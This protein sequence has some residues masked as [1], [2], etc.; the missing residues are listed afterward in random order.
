MKKKLNTSKIFIFA[1]ILFLGTLA[2]I[3]G[4]RFIHY[5]R[6]YHNTTEINTTVSEPVSISKHI[7]SF[8]GTEED[9]ANNKPTSLQ[10]DNDG[11]YYF[12]GQVKNNYIYYSGLLWRI[13]KLN[14]D[15][16]VTL[17]TEENQTQ[18]TYG[19][20]NKYEKSYVYNYL[21]KV[22]NNSVFYNNLINTD[23]LTKT[24]YCT[25]IINNIEDIT[26]S[27]TNYDYQITLLS[28]KDYMNSGANDGYLNNGTYFWLMNFN[29]N[30]KLYYVFDKGGVNSTNQYDKIHYGIRPVIS[31]KGDII[32]NGGDGTSEKPF[33]IDEYENYKLANVGIGEYLEYSGYNW[34]IINKTEDAVKVIMDGYIK[35][36]N[37]EIEKTFSTKNN[38]FTP[39]DKNNI[40]YYLNNDFY[41][42]LDNKEYLVKGPFYTGKYSTDSYD[43]RLIY[44]TNTNAYIGLP[45][46]GDLYINSFNNTLTMLGITDHMN[47]IL[48]V[49]DENNSLYT[50][51]INTQEKIRP[52]LYLN[53]SLITL[54]GEGTQKI[55]YIIGR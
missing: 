43:Y 4:Y 3:Y 8:R 7:L 51:K 46:I 5:Y 25:S 50:S 2:I 49:I 55:P 33:Y 44:K 12:K 30:N 41:K 16:T 23:Y 13:V 42:T 24:K 54:N 36:D 1:S 38:T 29:D 17:I 31:I 10:K 34:R 22:D 35:E 19:E 9:I 11:T 45:Q 32:L 18:L 20:T 27:K 14:E 28:V 48:Y 21:N 53:G 39:S 37:I 52:V 6:Y 40:G 26:C 15:N 47:N